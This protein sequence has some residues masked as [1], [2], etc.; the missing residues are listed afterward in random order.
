MNEKIKLARLNFANRQ[1]NTSILIRL[2]NSP[3]IVLL[4]FL[5]SYVCRCL[6]RLIAQMLKF[7]SYDWKMVFE[8]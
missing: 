5:V 1:K 8:I 6:A 4:I 2:Y 7:E 3:L